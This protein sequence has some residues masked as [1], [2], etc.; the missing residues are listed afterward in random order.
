MTTPAQS[1][2]VASP[3]IRNCCL[4][5]DNICLGCG[6][7]LG[8]IIRWSNATASEKEDILTRSRRRIEQRR[9]ETGQP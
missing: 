3:C 7:S 6:R 5:D 8:E 2:S 9:G 4:D 1:E